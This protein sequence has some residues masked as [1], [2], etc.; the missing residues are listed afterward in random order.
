MEK[1]VLLLNSTFEPMKVLTWQKAVMLYFGGK[2]K[3][4]ESYDDFDLGTQRFTMPCPA[5]VVLLKY[6]NLNNKKVT[7]SRT[8]VFSRDNYSC[9]YCSIQPGASNLTFDHV[10]PRSRGG[11]TEWENILTCCYPCNFHKADRTPAEAKMKPI[12]EPIRPHSFAALAKNFRTLTT[13]AEWETY[14]PK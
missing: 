3:I 7:F 12:K 1:K 11:R 14:L 5:V 6:V 8:N 9:M 4:I 2:V 13:P 10:L